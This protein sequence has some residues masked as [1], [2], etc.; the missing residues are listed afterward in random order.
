VKKKKLFP[1]YKLVV[2]SVILTSVVVVQLK[3]GWR[4]VVFLGWWGGEH[5]YKG[6]CVGTDQ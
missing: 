4:E 3:M 6:A 5:D 1:H 2:L